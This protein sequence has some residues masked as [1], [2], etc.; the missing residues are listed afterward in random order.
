M[1]SHL[2]IGDFSGPLVRQGRA[3]VIF[4]LEEGEAYRSLSFI[5]QGG[6]IYI[7]TA[8]EKFPLEPFKEI[9]EKR[10][11]T[12][13]LINATSIAAELQSLPSANLVLLGRFIAT[14][15]SFS[16]DSVEK[17]IS[18]TGNPGVIEKNLHAFRRGLG[19]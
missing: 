8:V 16:A 13:V 4:A 18:K 15:K 11:V 1:V 19:Q 5:R 3:S 9:L 2:R 6:H 17:A 10:N 12:S 14:E 7:D